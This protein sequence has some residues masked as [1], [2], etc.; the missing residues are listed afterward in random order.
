M[1]ERDI[2]IGIDIDNTLTNASSPWNISSGDIRD[3]NIAEN[4]LLVDERPGIEVL[5]KC[6]RKVILITARHEEYRNVTLKWLQKKSIKYERVVMRNFR[7]S[8]GVF[9]LNEYLKYKYISCL[10]HNIKY[11]LDDDEKVVNMLNENGIISVL[12]DRK[13][14]FDTAYY[15]LLEKIK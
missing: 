6:E 4:L 5:S 7:F 1:T 14:R 15:Q 11:M 12:V 13:G 2:I 9:N 8:G 3:M 10:E